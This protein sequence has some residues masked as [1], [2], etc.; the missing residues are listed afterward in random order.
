MYVPEAVSDGSRAS[1]PFGQGAAP[2]EAGAV[3][4]V[5]FVTDADLVV[6]SWHDAGERTYDWSAAEASGRNLLTL[7][8]VEPTAASPGDLLPVLASGECWSG[9]LWVQDRHGKRSRCR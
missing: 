2:S 6:T 4:Q 7:L 5:A 3:G 8:G 9:D 1:A